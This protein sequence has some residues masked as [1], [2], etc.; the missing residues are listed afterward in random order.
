[1]KKV[2]SKAIQCNNKINNRNSKIYYRLLITND[3][4]S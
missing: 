3:N 2:L 1:M 4:N